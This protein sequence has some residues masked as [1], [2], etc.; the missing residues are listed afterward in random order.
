MSGGWSLTSRMTS[1]RSPTPRMSGRRSKTPM[2][3][4]GRSPTPRVS[5]AQNSKHNTP[6]RQLR[7][8]TPVSLKDTVEVT[9]TH[10]EGVGEI[11]VQSKEQS[12]RVQEV[13][14]ELNTPQTLSPLPRELVEE[15]RRHTHSKGWRDSH[16]KG[17]RDSHSKGWRDSQTY[18]TCTCDHSQDGG[19]QSN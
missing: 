17:W 13:M 18:C 10:V 15:G 2:T 4:S 6:I 5:S 12:E 8:L 11:F 3:T 14:K 7:P 1:G 19:Q 9:V 16:S